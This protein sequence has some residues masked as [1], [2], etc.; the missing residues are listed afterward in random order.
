MLEPKGI[1]D[2]NIFNVINDLLPLTKTRRYDRTE[3]KNFT[4]FRCFVSLLFRRTK[5]KCGL[6]TLNEILLKYFTSLAHTALK[7]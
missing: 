7:V 1:I 2:D 3:K 6:L 5:V 4:C